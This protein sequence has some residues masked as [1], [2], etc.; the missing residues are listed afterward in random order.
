MKLKHLAG[1]IIIAILSGS[2]YAHDLSERYGSLLGALLHPLT[3]L[4][5]ALAFSALGLYAGLQDLR[6]THRIVIAFNLALLI[7]VLLP[8]LT[9][10]GAFASL[11]VV[12]ITSVVV[13]GAL[14]A[15]AAR[16]PIS[17]AMTLAVFFGLSHG[18]ENGSDLSS[19]GAWPSALG[20]FL[21]GVILTV[22]TAALA[23][24]LSSGYPRVAVRVAGSWIT[25][26]GLM[27]LG[28]QLR[29]A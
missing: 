16:L 29:Q 14:T 17:V 23:S 25:A 15:F 10:T 21:A 3:A 12:N 6:S 19:I 2:A 22:P 8:T 1:G 4:D 24:R 11:G 28:L 18:L 26:I 7:G 13:L 9:A 27:I 5:H 20:V